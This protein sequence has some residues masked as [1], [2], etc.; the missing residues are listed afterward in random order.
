MKQQI[1]IIC[2]TDEKYV[3]NTGVMLTSLCEHNRNVRIFIVVSHT[4]KSTYKTKFYKLAD[5]YKVELNFV[6][7]D[8]DLLASC[9]TIENMSLATY[10]K[11]FAAHLVDTESKVIYLDSDIIINGSLQELWETDMTD[12]AFAGVQDLYH[13]DRTT[14]DR[15]QYPMEFG[16][17]NAGMMIFNL[18]YWRQHN[19]LKQCLT[20]IADNRERILWCEQDVLNALFFDRKK[21]LPLKFNYQIAMLQR[22]FYESF[23]VDFQKCI[24]DVTKPIV[25][26]YV[27]TDK[28]WMIDYYRHPFEKEWQ[29]YK[30]MSLWRYKLPLFP[31]TNRLKTI[32]KRYI[33]WPLGWKRSNPYILIKE[34]L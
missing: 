23:S 1:N 12:Y 28:P 30:R 32:L 25:I 26:H 20:Y 24:M 31:K 33:L 11:I 4:F 8:L 34:K 15:L 14:Y 17:Y 29:K 9:P 27:G 3:H 10:Y 22:C 5:K 13:Q 18:D 7:I 2:S 16:Y 19:V 21:N 6:S